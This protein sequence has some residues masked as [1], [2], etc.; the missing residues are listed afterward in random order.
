MQIEQ[1]ILSRLRGV[2]IELLNEFVRICIENNLTYFL[3][4]GTLL[5]AVRHKGFI[6]WDDDIDVGMPRKDYELFLDIISAETKTNYYILSNRSPISSFYH[7]NSYAKFC[8]KG[9]IIAKNNLKP[10]D[11]SGIFIDIWPYD[12]CIKFLL[13]LHSNINSAAKKLYFLKTKK[14]IPQNRIKYWISRII[15]LFFTLRFCRLLLDKSYT[16]FNNCNTK[17]ISF[18]SALYG[19]KRETHGLDTIYPLSSIYFEGNIYNAPNNYNQFLTELYGNFMKLP[20]IEQQK[21]HEHINISF[22]EAIY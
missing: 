12:N 7:Y 4:A 22:N 13:P 11:Y 5:G 17:Y 20:P 9:T 19:Y 2:M 8:K 15:C 21:A 3:T 14:D 18:F 16:I 1:N 6:P 10:Q